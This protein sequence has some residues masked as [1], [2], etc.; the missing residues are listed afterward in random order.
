MIVLEYKAVL[1]EMMQIINK[2]TNA[3]KIFA[4]Y[5]LLSSKTHSAAGGLTLGFVFG[6]SSWHLLG[7]TI[8]NIN[9]DTRTLLTAVG[10]ADTNTVR[11]KLRHY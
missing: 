11:H 10:A 8:R 3:F 2:L 5:F 7:V 4:H 9:Q 6:S 1:W